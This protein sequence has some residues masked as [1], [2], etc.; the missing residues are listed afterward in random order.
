M[1]RVSERYQAAQSVLLLFILAAPIA[2]AV[3]NPALGQVE[4]STQPMQ[5]QSAPGNQNDAFQE[6]PLP[7]ANDQ[8]KTSDGP[9]GESS[10]ELPEIVV[11][12]P[13]PSQPKQT[14]ENGSSAP[15]IPVTAQADAPTNS[16][17]NVVRPE[18]V[19]LDTISQRELED[20]RLNRVQDITRQSSGIN[21]PGFGD[22]RSTTFKVRGLGP[23]VD[24]LSP[25]ETSFVVHI[26]G[27]PQPLFGAD[28]EYLDLEQTELLK[29]P[30]GTRFG[31]N[32][33]AGSLNI[34]TRKP[35]NAPEFSLRSEIGS[36]GYTLAEAIAS[37][38][39]ISQELAG[40]L[41]LRFSDIDGFVLNTQTGNELGEKK[42]LSGR[43]T[44]LY[45]PDIDT[46]VTLRFSS[47]HDQRTFPFFL[48]RNT[49]EYPIAALVD[50]NA[51]RRR[52][53]SGTV[54]VEHQAE[55]YAV[56]SITNLTHLKTS[57]LYIDDTDGFTF[58]KLTGLPQS[59][60]TPNN[61]FTD[62]IE[63]QQTLSQQF[64]FSSPKAADTQWF[65]GVFYSHSHFSADYLN[66]S[67]ISP[68]VNGR[69]LNELATDSY[70]GFGEITLPI[71]EK[72]R[73]T[74]GGR[75]THERKTYDLQYIGIGTPGTVTAFRDF[76]DLN[77]SFV[78]GRTVLAYDIV[79]DSTLYASVARGFKSGGFPR[80][81]INASLGD[82]TEP[83]RSAETW[84]YEVGY[85]FSPSHSP[86]T[87]QTT[88]YYNDVTNEHLLVFDP[89]AINF[90]PA[91]ADIVSYGVE[92][93]A[94]ATLGEA[95]SIGA[96][97]GYTR[98]EVVS[99]L[100]GDPV[101]GAENADR[102]VNVPELTSSAILEYSQP[103]Q[104]LDVEIDGRFFGHLSWSFIGDRAA[105]LGNS[106]FL[107][108]YHL[109]SGRFGFEHASGLEIYAFG[110]NLLDEIPQLT[111]A[112][113]PP[114]AELVAPGRGRLV[115][116]G[117][118]QRW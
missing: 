28:T 65:A 76:G 58:S 71:A 97:I 108:P 117:V 54:T 79:S 49:P 11:T 12:T 80:L 21:T 78:T 85:K 14:G 23:L 102:P 45:T 73:F 94:K 29:G 55:S 114:N 53:N 38:P 111:G 17:Q 48:L 8:N 75:L 99:V 113:I 59:V 118:A 87:F 57:D 56:K 112:F 68:R 19:A 105:D 7:A 88:A 26:D 89:V 66:E 77:F 10:D 51:S 83:F 1:G 41:A 13:A 107:D 44:L 67:A 22:G 63:D 15:A 24:A 93:S 6:T 43:A 74:L 34:T 116:I 62:W 39:I 20:Q 115:G 32:T 40:R 35:K 47:D 96:N 109:V 50:D 52:V 106:F 9:M 81:V 36:D 33:T 69:R 64:L 2:F 101:F 16:Q 60:F 104:D 27:V 72:F 91:N 5:A 82:V 98:A 42:I 103:A 61:T 3:A 31:R 100:S 95:F 84:T 18:A 37:G 46:S 92:V 86:A 110:N 90:F 30:Q 70:A 4:Q 25:D